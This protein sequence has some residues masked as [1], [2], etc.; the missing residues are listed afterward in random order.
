MN[1][2]RAYIIGALVV[3]L[4]PVT[5]LASSEMHFLPDGSITATNVLVYQKAGSNLFCRA[6]WGTAFV[7]FVLLANSST[8]ITKDHGEKATVADIAEKDVISFDGTLSTGADSLVIVAKNIRD[9]ALQS[10]DKT[11]AGIVSS[12]DTSANTFVLTDKVFGKITVAV[13]SATITKGARTISINEMQV[14]DKVL[15]APGTYDY[16][17]KMLAAT[18]ISLFQTDSVFKPRNFEGSLKS[19]S[20][21]SLP[22]TLVV[23]VG[24]TDYAV[25]LGEKAAVLSKNKSATLLTRLVVGDKVR[26]YGTIRKTNL[27]EIDA[28]TLRDLNF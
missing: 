27:T 11:V 19:I 22:V 12:V 25:Y 15:S 26:L 13:S 3:L 28:D 4:L 23:T 16:T 17:S 7:R 10:A 21:T 18:S 14:G 6:T 20:G 1:F 24:S 5:A 9:S 2:L 8:V